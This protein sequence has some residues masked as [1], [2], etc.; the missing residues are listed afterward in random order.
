MAELDAKMKQYM[1]DMDY[2]VAEREALG[3]LFSDILTNP[4][5]GTILTK[6]IGWLS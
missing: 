4:V 2:S 1:S 5:A 3:G 6:F